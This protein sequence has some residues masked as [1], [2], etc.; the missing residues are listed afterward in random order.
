MNCVCKTW[1]GTWTFV[2]EHHKNCPHY[3]PEGDAKK[4][5]DAL[6]DGIDRWADEC[7]HVHPAVASAYNRAAFSV[8]RKQLGPEK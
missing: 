7:G 5:I 4:I 2:T 8:G 1:G 6:L 3:D